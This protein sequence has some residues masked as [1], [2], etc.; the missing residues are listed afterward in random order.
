ML[1]FFLLCSDFPGDFLG[2]LSLRW[3]RDAMQSPFLICYGR[4]G[5]EAE[6]GPGAK[7]NLVLE[8]DGH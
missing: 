1:H 6:H 4:N 2:R 5:S 7:D 3:I 8:S